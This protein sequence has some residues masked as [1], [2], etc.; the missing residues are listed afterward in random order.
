MM[1]RWTLRSWIALG[2]WLIAFPVAMVV[3][4]GLLTWLAA[5]PDNPAF[6][7]LLIPGGIGTVILLA[8]LVASLLL[9][10]RGQREGD[11][12]ARVPMIIS[13]ALL[14]VLLAQTMLGIVGTI[15]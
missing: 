15:F 4:E 14:V 2:C 13:G 10:R 11:D 5:D 1:N 9:G 6:T 12:R 7:D 3:G 8:P